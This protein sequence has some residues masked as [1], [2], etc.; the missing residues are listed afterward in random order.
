MMWMR[1]FGSL[2]VL[3]FFVG[4]LFSVFSLSS[5]S[6]CSNVVCARMLDGE[7]RLTLFSFVFHLLLIVPMYLVYG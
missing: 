4:V 3:L 7:I 6:S 5:V 1:S 2:F